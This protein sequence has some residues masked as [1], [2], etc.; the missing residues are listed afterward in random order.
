MQEDLWK[1]NTSLPAGTV[2]M[3]GIETTVMGISLLGETAMKLVVETMVMGMSL[4]TGNV[5]NG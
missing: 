4:L 3:A 5:T 2:S 1:P